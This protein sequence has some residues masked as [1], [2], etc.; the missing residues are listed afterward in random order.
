MK[1]IAILFCLLLP[2]LLSAQTADHH[3][4]INLSLG[5]NWRH[6]SLLNQHVGLGLV[7][8]VDSLRGFDLQLLLGGVTRQADGVMISGLGNAAHR[9]N[10]LQLAGLTNLTFRPMKGIQLSG[11][12][13]IAMGVDLGMQVAAFTNVN[14][15]NMH[16]LQIAGYNY[17]DT[18]N[19]SQL[20]LINVAVSH[21]K[22]VQVGIIN[23]THDTIA[24][25]IGL[26]NINP[27]TKIDYLVG[28]GTSSKLNGALRF[29]NRSTYSIIGVGTHYMGFD[30]DF[31]GAIFYRLGQYFNL[32]KRW[33]LSGDVGFYHIETFSKDES[34]ND[35]ERLFSLQAHLNAD[36][37]ISPYLG[38]YASVGFGTTRRYGSWHNYRTRPLLETGLTISY[39]H[40]G[41]SDQKWMDERQRDLRWH[42]EK[43]R[44]TPAGSLFRFDDPE[45][46]RNRWLPAVSEAV[47]INVF[48]HCF[49]RFVMNEDFAQVHFKDIAH[50]WRHAFVWDNDQFS[51]NLFAHPY[52]GNLYFNSARSNGLN[53]WQSAPFSLGGSL[54]W[55]FCGEVEPPAINDVM[56]TTM[57][58]I[59]IGEI[60]HRISALI[61]NDRTRGRRRFWREALAT[62]INPM[63]G[64][65]RLTNGDAWTVRDS[66]YL[67][68]DFSRIPVEFAVSAGDRYLADQGSFAR[69][70]HQPFVEFNLFYG[71]AFDTETTEPYDYFTLNLIAGFTGNQPLINNLHLLGKLWSRGYMSDDGTQT[72]FGIFQH[73]NYYDSKPVKDGSR[74][75][76]YRI[77]EA[78]S[79]GPGLLWKFPQV[80]NLA[81]LRQEIYLDGILLGGTKS[82]YYN[83]ID[84]DYNM[85]SGFSLKSKTFMVFPRMG[86]FSVLVDYYRIFTW[87]GYEGKDLAK[88]DPL[89]L[90]AQG[91]KSNAQLLVIQPKFLFQLKHNW[92]IEM[93]GSFFGRYTQYK[94]HDNVRTHTYEVR[95]GL[96]YRL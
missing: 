20:G 61:L 57:G 39:H 32:S 10:G 54:M 87:K 84:R 81:Y 37:R 2:L 58:G 92:G 52:H 73:F 9:L 23:Y 42:Q 31:S 65:T 96:V 41:E 11:I 60:T 48:V 47:G 56:A 64:L 63:Q 55:E 43:L 17:A 21:P 19:G 66:N 76:P 59:C 5:L 44:E 29:R 93:S 79:V 28:L 34:D 72:V 6:D 40:N 53:F 38:A 91:D 86:A 36:Y 26:V 82:D 7:S 4:R 85:G 24:H 3:R 45:Y 18:L 51:T 8:A 49:D 77:S 27:K 75:T 78:A 88:T 12:S 69:G 95:M 13:N 15:G 1:K 50:N 70:E 67:Y 71:D 35:A 22:G 30:D 74:Q 94:Y 80:G 62:V 90:N 25:K 83:V 89:Y 16:G 14:S 46:T 68:H 33:S